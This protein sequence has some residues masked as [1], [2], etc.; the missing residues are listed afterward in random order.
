MSLKDIFG[1]TP[2]ILVFDELAANVD[3]MTVEQVV[4]ASGLSEKEVI[5]ALDKLIENGLVEKRG[6][7]YLC[8]DCVM[9]KCLISAVMIH[10]FEMA[11]Q[12][13]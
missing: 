9:T 11:K 12:K 5:R 7:K 10:S 2:E 1:E 13:E 4:E 8:K 6:D 3:E